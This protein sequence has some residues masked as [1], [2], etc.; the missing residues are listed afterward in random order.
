MDF[1]FGK[2]KVMSLAE[3]TSLLGSLRIPTALVFTPTNL[4]S[5]KKK[6]FRYFYHNNG[7]YVR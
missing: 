1:L 7:G 4:E 2:K 5:E 3:V 6:F